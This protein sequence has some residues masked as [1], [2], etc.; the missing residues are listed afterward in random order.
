M[1]TINISRKE[2]GQLDVPPDFDIENQTRT[3]HRRRAEALPPASNKR[4]KPSF[5]G[6]GVEEPEGPP[7]VELPQNGQD[8]AARS[9]Y[10]AAEG[11]GKLK[12]FGSLYRARLTQV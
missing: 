3:R 1:P 7:V 5:E 4:K 12:P 10:P 2:L 9:R 11:T 8:T 6:N